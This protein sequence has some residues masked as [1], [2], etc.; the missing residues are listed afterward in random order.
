MSQ[1]VKT[2]GLMVSAAPE[3][4]TAVRGPA[5]SPGRGQTIEGL[6][7]TNLTGTQ[8][9]T[10]RQ[11]DFP[12]DFTEHEDHTGSAKGRARA[13]VRFTLPSALVSEIQAMGG[14][15][16]AAVLPPSIMSHGV[17]VYEANMRITADTDNRPGSSLNVAY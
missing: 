17:A 9:F 6:S 16:Q 7:S 10:L 4:A 5:F 12:S 15:G 11:E 3:R 14:F 2:S 1:A 8:A 13:S